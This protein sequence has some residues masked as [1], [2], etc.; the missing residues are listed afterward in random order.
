ML[1]A[2]DVGN[3]ETVLGVFDSNVLT[4]HWR[5][6]T[7]PDRTAD[8][9]AFMVGGFLA[10]EGL[11][12]REDVTG[13]AVASVVP[14]LT[15]SLRQMVAR[16]FPFS[17]VVVEPGTR[18]GIAI[19]FD[20]PKDVGADRIANAAAAHAKFGGPSVVV[21]FGTATTFD[22]VSANAEYLGGVIA[23]GIKVSADALFGAAA[24]LPRV[25]IVP[26]R[27]IVAKTTVESVQAGLVYGTAGMVDG[28]IERIAKE[29]GAPTVVATG[30]LAPLVVD[31]CA[32]V[33]HH[34]PWL[35]LEG[36]R[37]IHERGQRSL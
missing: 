35:T 6:S 14:G 11:S 29:I 34:E 18:T 21:D 20:S 30:G 9:L 4:N 10:G 15:Q 13:V 5:S 23:P 32:S 16:Y 17:P 24:R 26:P 8:E 19:L 36:L 37:L 28:V 27:G 33:Q 2:I 3:T 25:E 1:L 7:D 12:L 31:Q 22:V